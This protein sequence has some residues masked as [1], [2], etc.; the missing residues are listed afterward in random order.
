MK[1]IVVKGLIDKTRLDNFLVKNLKQNRSFI[2]KLI[3][4]KLIK[5]NNE[6]INKGGF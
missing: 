4:N 2:D 6:I 5:V 3:K 1:K